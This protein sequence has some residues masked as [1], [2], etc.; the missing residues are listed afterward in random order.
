[1]GFERVHI[2]PAAPERFE[3][4]LGDR[5]QD[6]EAALERA[7]VLLAGR[8]VWNVN[9]T[10]AGGGV[11]EMLRPLVAY[12][13]GAGIEA[14]WLAVQAGP[15]FFQVTKRL[16]NKL[17]GVPGDG[18]DVGALEA[19]TYERTLA[20]V[21]AEL[22][23][24]I[25]PG[26]I[27][28]LHDPQTAGMV[29]SLKAKGAIV[30][31]RCHVGLDTPND[32]A[33]EAWAFLRPW[34]EVA[35]KY[36][37]SRQVFVWEDLDDAKIAIIPPSI[38]AF[39]P[40]NQ[41]ME[42]AQVDAILRAAELVSGSPSHPAVFVRSD[43]SEGTVGRRAEVRGAGP[44][45]SDVEF[46]LQVSRWD[47]LKDP[48]GVVDGFARYVAGG[49]DA[50]LVLAGP[51]VEDVADD[52]EG[53][54]VL[55]EVMDAW[56][57]LEEAVKPR[58]HLAVLPMDD[59]EENA[60]IVNAL[61]RAATVVVQK[62]LAEGFGLTVAEAMWKGRPVVASRIGGIQDQIIHGETGLLLDDARDL[63]GFGE[64]VNRF[65]DDPAYARDVGE[66]AQNRVKEAFLGPRHLMQYLELLEE[67]IGRTASGSE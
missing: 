29:A 66:A 16:H 32:H 5:W 37:F 63:E 38:D 58:V 27:V 18:G 23:E 65:L 13:K 64:A 59:G 44:I 3:S 28:L 60:A 36:V 11:A 49:G 45:P 51:A 9:S 4:V 50:H 62:S 14:A 7:H 48:I 56:E 15:A 30:I 46:V 52:P 6:F 43:G 41:E 57:A 24:L 25:S 35:D 12:I 54:E 40:K 10:A 22:A 8:T 53:A 42:K 21:G 33:R 67:L 34:V 26:D 55:L 2:E 19:E 47:R 31:W 39:S 17:H 61:Q 20:K 1:M